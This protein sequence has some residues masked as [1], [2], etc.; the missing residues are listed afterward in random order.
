[1]QVICFQAEEDPSTGG[2]VYVLSILILFL[3]P[4]SLFPRVDSCGIILIR[5]VYR[6]HSRVEIPFSIPPTNSPI[7]HDA[8]HQLTIKLPRIFLDEEKEVCNRVKSQLSSSSN[9]N[10]DGGGG[11]G[12]KG[13]DELV[14]QSY[15]N[16]VFV[17]TIAVVT[18]RLVGPLMQFCVERCERNGR[19]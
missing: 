14:A 8:L 1:M 16:G 6:H 2:L 12:V 3:P 18:D 19:V 17:E 5:R 15:H 10:A 7:S 11:G 13:A 9:G 4:S